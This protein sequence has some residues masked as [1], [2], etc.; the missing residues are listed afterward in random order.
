MSYN[1]GDRVMANIV[2]GNLN[3]ENAIGVIVHD[4]GRMVLVEFVENIGGHDGE[5]RGADGHCWWLCTS[6]LDPAP[7]PWADM[8]AG[9]T[10]DD[11][12]VNDY[13]RSCW[14]C[15]PGGIV[16]RVAFAAG[17]LLVCPHCGRVCDGRKV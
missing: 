4:S 3:K 9:L 6:E 5:G 16:D 2:V 13:S 12:P 8:L 15:Q 17:G 14:Y 10:L 7:D 1:V 11:S